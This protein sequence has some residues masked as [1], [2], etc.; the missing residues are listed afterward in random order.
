MYVPSHTNDVSHLVDTRKVA[1]VKELSVFSSAE[2]K[3]EV[4]VRNKQKGRN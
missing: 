3:G 1:R 2:L 4:N